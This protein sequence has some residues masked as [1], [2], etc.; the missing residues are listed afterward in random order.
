MGGYGPFITFITVKKL[1]HGSRNV[2]ELSKLISSALCQAM[3]YFCEGFSVP[4]SSNSTGQV[5]S[6]EPVRRN[7][8]RNNNS[9]H[10]R[11]PQRSNI[12]RW[13]LL[14]RSTMMV[15]SS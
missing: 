1:N 7:S 15:F 12:N 8:Y 13:N 14:R 5:Q 4:V 9:Y 2:L 10:S 6:H 3:R 11:F